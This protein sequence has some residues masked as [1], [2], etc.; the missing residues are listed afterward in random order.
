[1]KTINYNKFS[2][3][4]PISLDSMYNKTCIENLDYNLEQIINIEAPITLNILKERLRNALNVKKISQKALDIIND[5]I[6]NL[7]FV[8]TNNFYDIAL[9]PKTG[10]F[11]I[12]YVRI[13][14]R[15]IYDIAKEELSVLG[16]KIKNDG[17]NGEEFMRKVL[18]FFGYEVLTKKAYDYLKFIL[19]YV[20]NI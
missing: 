3:F 12:D 19:E 10:V 13:S 8:K 7:G 18:E 6:N 2:D 5:R 17:Y 16:K 20:D 9:W 15:Q 14:N 1:M 11:N 4:K